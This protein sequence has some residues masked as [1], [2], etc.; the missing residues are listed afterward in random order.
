MSMLTIYA[1]GYAWYASVTLVWR[2]WYKNILSG[3]RVEGKGR[4]K[5]FVGPERAV[6]VDSSYAYECRGL[7]LSAEQ[8]QEI[9]RSYKNAWVLLVD[10]YRRFVHTTARWRNKLPV[11]APSAENHKVWPYRS[12]IS[13][14][15]DIDGLGFHSHEHVTYLYSTVNFT[16][17]PPYMKLRPR[18]DI[19]NIRKRVILVSSRYDA[20]QVGH[21]F[22]F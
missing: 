7:C 4:K 5:G 16:R 9:C 2:L 13:R 1:L 15:A 6:V 3:V 17:T 14:D 8:A 20:M 11:A 19:K 21:G 18:Y 22:G 12:R 10:V